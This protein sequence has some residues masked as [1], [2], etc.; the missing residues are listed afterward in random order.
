M[1]KNSNRWRIALIVLLLALLGLVGRSIAELD[2]S[3]VVS[4]ADADLIFVGEDIAD[5][6]G[7]FASPAGD[8]NGDGLDDILVGAPMAGDKVCPYPPNPDGSCPD[9]YIPKGQ[10]V[11]YLVL[12]RPR[13]EWPPNP[14]NLAQADAS[15]LGCE[16]NSMTARQ[17]YTAG[18]VNGDGYDDI[19]ISGW[20]CGANFT[21]KAYLFLGRPDVGSWGRYFPVEEAD[22]SFL[23]ENEWDFLSYYVSTANDVNGDGYDDFL[24]TSTHYD[25]P[26][27]QVIGNAGKTYLILGRQAADWGT[28]YPVALADASF[29]GEA[30]EDRL[31]RSANGVGD[32]NG[33]GYDD[34]VIGSISSDYG[35]IDAGQNYL[36]LGRAT[37][38]D[39]DYDPAR[40]WWGPNYSVAGA[41]A[42]FIGEAEGDE[43][44]R[45]VAGAGDVN[46]DGYSDFLIGAARNSHVGHW[47]GIAHL[48]L[49]RPEADW[50]MHYPL[51]DADASFV[52]EQ[53]SDQAGRRLS[54]AGDVNSDGHDDFIIGAPHNQRGSELEG[55]HAGTAYLIYGRPYDDDWWGRYYPL[56]QADIIYVGK[57]DVGVAGY[58]QAWLGDFD[59]DSIDDFLIAAYGGRNNDHTPGEVY[60]LLGSDAPKPME[61]IPNRPEGYVR[62][63]Q[64]FTGVYWDP[65]G[66]EDLSRVQLVLGRA[67]N[68]P[69]G[70]NVSYNPVGNAF[71][72]YGSP[73][74]CSP[75]EEGVRL[76]NDVV[77]LGCKD[78]TVD[79]GP[80]GSLRVTWRARW[81]QPILT[82]NLEINAYLR[83]ADLSGNDSGLME[84][85]TWTLKWEDLV[86]TKTVAPATWVSPGGAPLTYTLTF[87]NAGGT[88]ASNVTITDEVPNELLNVSFVSNCPLTPT[89]SV[90]YTWLV[91]DLAPGQGGVITLSGM[92]DPGLPDGY[93]F[94]NIATIDATATDGDPSNNKE[95]VR[96]MVGEPL[97]TYLPLL[98]K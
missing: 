88:I 33:D 83:A 28:D 78:S 95:T 84:F 9:P 26:G 22:A 58:D 43:S 31:G 66:W 15:F 94:T 5:W 81:L 54:G 3:F 77:E 36:F 34:F 46:G 6:A 64:R 49:G 79:V 37:E 21:G 96:V 93:T 67:T 1:G 75:G 51:T 65:N 25:I 90:P 76:S 61:F 38:D 62:E 71:S 98:L 72:L 97:R 20:K 86:L 29:L 42:S 68:D 70:L 14:V 91:G 69:R 59:G 80:S 53:A 87:S 30:E 89:G 55:I 10:G 2:E 41:D 63:W 4:L 39:P 74:F 23:G 16:V 56:A 82:T 24:I 7:Y 13:E 60:V 35:G 17:L 47:S 92:V 48:I 73:E 18:D 57:P 32:V 85:G 45:R 19:L 40:P 12:G 50:G 52:G 27:A 8:V 11:A 44:G